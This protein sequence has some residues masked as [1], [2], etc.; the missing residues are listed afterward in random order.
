MLA[1]HI[2]SAFSTYTTDKRAL[3]TEVFCI[4]INST[5]LLKV[6]LIYDVIDRGS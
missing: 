3:T 2:K 4:V 5:V 1:V 6:L